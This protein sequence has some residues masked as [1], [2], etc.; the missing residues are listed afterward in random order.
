MESLALF[1][2]ILL[3]F[4]I[5]SGPLALFITSRWAKQLSDSKYVLVLRRSFLAAIN[6]LGMF[7]SLSIIVVA[8]PIG[9]KFLAVISILLHVLSVN[10]EYQFFSHKLSG[11]PNGPG[12]QD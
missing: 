10:R 12:G 9:V 3:S 4:L 5:F 8:V 2:T 6:I 11:D 7:I 1:A